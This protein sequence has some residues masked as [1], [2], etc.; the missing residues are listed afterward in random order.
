MAMTGHRP[1]SV[2]GITDRTESRHRR[3]N[4]RT[5]ATNV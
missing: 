2:L 4:G 3:G 1:R 5:S